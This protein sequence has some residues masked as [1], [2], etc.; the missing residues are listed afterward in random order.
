MHKDI[1][2]ISIT[3]STRSLWSHIA[4]PY[5]LI[6][7]LRYLGLDDATIRFLSRESRAALCSEPSSVTLPLKGMDFY[8]LGMSAIQKAGTY[9]LS[10]SMLVWARETLE[11]LKWP[12]PF[13]CFNLASCAV[14]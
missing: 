7:I 14:Q 3:T 11:V 4:I 9:V 1:M 6:S 2:S 13:R 5:L 8:Q 12:N 10:Q